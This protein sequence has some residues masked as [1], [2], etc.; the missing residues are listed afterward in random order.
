[1]IIMRQGLNFF[2]FSLAITI[3][4][5]PTALSFVLR[6]TMNS[7]HVS[8]SRRSPL[9]LLE[10]NTATAAALSDILSST[11]TTWQSP[12]DVSTMLSSTSQFSP[13]ALLLADAA[14]ASSAPPE[15]GGLS[16]SRASYYTVLGL[17]VLSFPGLWSTI[18]RS[19][20]AKIKRKTFVSPGE[21]STVAPM[22]IAKEEEEATATAD[23]TSTTTSTAMGRS[24]RQEAGE[25]MACTYE[26][27]K[28]EIL[29]FSC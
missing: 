22:V 8:S 14:T 2:F 16:Y 29:C 24:L 18:K 15:A 3:G 27:E 4:G 1:M 19:T 23:T 12:T 21:K 26:G 11:A 25:I 5:S 7:H 13:F 17:Y 9:H 10:P 6:P 20:T 28:S